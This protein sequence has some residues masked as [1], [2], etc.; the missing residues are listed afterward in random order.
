MNKRV[1]FIL[2]AA[3]FLT[4]CAMK[5]Q[6]HPFPREAGRMMG[7]ESCNCDTITLVELATPVTIFD[8]GV[9]AREKTDGYITFR[10]GT[11]RRYS[12]VKGALYVDEDWNP[13]HISG[14]TGVVR[15]FISGKTR[16][17]SRAYRTIN[18]V[19]QMAEL[20]NPFDGKSY[21]LF[22]RFDGESIELDIFLT[23]R[24]SAKAVG[25]LEDAYA[26][27]IYDRR[28]QMNVVRQWASASETARVDG[29]KVW[30]HYPDGAYIIISN[31]KG[32]QV[33]LFQGATVGKA[34][35]ADA[36]VDH[37]SVVYIPKGVGG[38]LERDMFL[39]FYAS[40]FAGEFVDDLENLPDCLNTPEQRGEGGCEIHNMVLR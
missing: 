11:E 7:N 40:E 12:F 25:Y 31:D 17:T 20:L 13:L 32:N 33:K 26:A 24:P 23:P 29:N 18:G 35:G 2:L 5:K 19:E 21:Y 22:A 38:D 30:H 1:C 15:D 27:R 8:Q 6:L 34:L 10:D 28:Y 4:A 36:F 3:V 39:F 9:V 37:K 16:R 14:S